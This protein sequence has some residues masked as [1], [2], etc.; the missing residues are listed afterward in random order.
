MVFAVNLLSSLIMLIYSTCFCI[1][2][3]RWPKLDLTH[4]FV[5]FFCQCFITLLLFSFQL[6]WFAHYW[7]VWI[8]LFLSGEALENNISQID[9][10]CILY[11]VV[12]SQSSLWLG[13]QISLHFK[14]IKWDKLMHICV[15]FSKCEY[16]I[17]SLQ[18][19]IYLKN[20]QH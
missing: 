14:T 3:H 18:S 16:P 6:L 1:L 8:Q 10:K 19:W 20:N 15:K 2:R 13:L 17:Q 5:N 11:K 7:R 12:K 4:N 9:L